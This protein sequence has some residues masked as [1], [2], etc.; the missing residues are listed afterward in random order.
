MIDLKK[1]L[2]L[3]R[4]TLLSMEG[5]PYIPFKN[6]IN[7]QN[8]KNFVIVIL[9]NFKHFRHRYNENPPPKT[10]YND[11]FPALLCI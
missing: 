9:T 11:N 6:L 5:G 3:G 7:E 8:F 1:S 10:R 2:I 4:Y